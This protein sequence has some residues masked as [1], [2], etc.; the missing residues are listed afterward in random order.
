MKPVKIK[1]MYCNSRSNNSDLV[2]I[3]VIMFFI[4]ITVLTATIAGLV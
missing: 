1:V 4:I 3:T 2:W